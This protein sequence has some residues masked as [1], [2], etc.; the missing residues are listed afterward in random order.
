MGR[1]LKGLSDSPVALETHGA[2]VNVMKVLVFCITAGLAA[3]AGALLASLF[4]YG[5]GTNYSSFASLT[6]VAILTIVVV[7]DPWYAILAA[8]AYGVVPGYITVANINTYL[9]IIFGLSAATFALQVNRALP[10]PLPI[11][12]FLDRIGGRAPEV[13]LSEGDVDA[14]VSQAARTERESA[15]SDRERAAAKSTVPA[16]AKA[17]LSVSDLAVQY[18]GVRAVD[19]VTLLAPMGRITG[20][21]GPNGAGKTT[22]FNA[23]SGLLKPTAGV[24]TL[25]ERDVTGIGPAGRS[26]YGLGRTFQKAELFNS[27]SVRENVE[28]GR[29]A[30]MAGANP[31]T[32]LIGSRRD[33]AVVRRAVDEAMEL[34]GIG[35][36][37]DLQAGLL[38]TG[39]RRLVELARVLAGP[40]DLLLLDEPSAGLDAG[41]TVSF[42][43]VLSGVVAERGAGILLV[44]HDMALVRQVC[45]HIYVLDFGRLVF[46]GSPAEMLNSDIVR[47]AYLGSEGVGDDGA[48]G[49]PG[50]APK[51]ASPPSSPPTGRASYEP[52]R[53][54][55]PKG[56]APVLELENITAG[57][58]DTVVLRDVSLSVPDSKV[59]A[60][61]GPNGAGKTTLLRVA[62]GLIKPM[63]GRVIL[64]G[65]DVTGKKP[66]YMC[67]KGLCNLPEGRGI[68]PSLT[69]R[70]NLILQSKKGKEQATIDLATQ[71]FPAL[72][73]RL[74]QTAGSLSGGEQQMLALV[75][76]FASEPRIVVVD[77][78]SLG[79]API[80]VD[81]I[82]ETLANIVSTGVSVLLV[83]Q[84][85]T[86]ALALADEACLLNRGQ[87]VFSGPAD[88]LEGDEIFE[89]YFGIEISA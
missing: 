3:V 75:R 84:Y 45:A 78:A 10:V 44:E 14:L 69:V 30:S 89:R 67:R 11:R 8:I 53:P 63:S 54:P 72:A 15:A 87:V 64:N 85:V 46:E 50:V 16:S 17:G 6:M 57:Y 47:A 31:V 27:L 82:F 42:G 24:I 9:T 5:L 48:P 20:L 66:F 79:L 51:R 25:H 34:T 73:T 68:F 83:E 43:N 35:P 7:G 28:L 39:Q 86:R 38:P 23:C 62:A 37:S 88:D 2:T 1:L 12:N 22:T 49:A 81:R 26:R 76:T 29:E 52:P 36:L 13:V 32:Q 58:G 18:G 55:Q 19:G 80:I 59:V 74:K 41:E 77:E 60:L 40:F 56:D 21:I 61:L 65:E 71:S 70:D 4:S 33:R